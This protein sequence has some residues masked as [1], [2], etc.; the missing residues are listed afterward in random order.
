MTT[1]LAKAFEKAAT[2]PEHLQDQIAQELTEEIEWELKWNQTLLDSR[3]LIDQLAEKAL[4][5]YREGRTKEMG[6][7]EL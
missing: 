4:K 6:F 1:T 3:E 7:D 2:L 5:E